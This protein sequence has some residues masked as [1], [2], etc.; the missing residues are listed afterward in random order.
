MTEQS[1][2][3][4]STKGERTSAVKVR[5]RY[6]KQALEASGY[7]FV[8]Y[9]MSLAGFKKYMSYFLRSPPKDLDKM[10]EK[11]SLVMTSSPPVLNAIIS[12]KIA[13]KHKLPLIIDVRDLWEEYAKTAHSLASY[14]GVVKRL[15]KEYYGA[16]HYASKIFVVTEPMKHYYERALNVKDKVI[17]VSNGTDTDIIRCDKSVERKRDLVYLADLDQPYHNVEFLL[18]AL[19]DST[20]NLT[21]IGDGKYLPEI[22]ES[23]RRLGVTGKVKFVGWVPYENLKEY[24]CGAKVGVVGRPFV[25]NVGYLYAIPVKTYD[26]LAA[27]LPVIGYGPKNSALE[28][29]I[30]R[31]AIGAYVSEPDPK[32]LLRELTNLVQ[33]HDKYVK[34]ARELAMSFD[35]KRIAQKVVE[36]VKEVLA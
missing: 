35:R 11:V 26:Y 4:V 13:T 29:F 18:R 7:N 12:Y 28:D 14:L 22:K 1:V 16:L 10:S 31:N 5:I 34:R 20:L 8:S 36:A 2:L 25:D 3:F 27:G 17:V 21:V 24:L 6:F 33:E 30:R 23:A 32:V 9:E 15:V 19:K